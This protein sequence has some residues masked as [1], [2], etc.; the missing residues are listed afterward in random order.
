MDIQRWETGDQIVVRSMWGEKFQAVLPMRVIA[1][2]GQVLVLYLAAGTPFKNRSTYHVN[3]LPV[4]EWEIV[5]DVWTDDLVRIMYTDDN[6]AY[7]AYWRDSRFGGWYINLE[8][9]YKRTSIGIDFTDH[10]LDIVVRPE[11]AG[12]DWKDEDELAEAV[13]LNLVTQSQADE[14]YEEGRRAVERLEARRPPFGEG[15]EDFI[16]N[17]AWEIPRLSPGWDM[18]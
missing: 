6:H 1:D 10:I 5:D 17:P 13:F 2:S 4:G 11:L 18:R 7:F 16:P 12:W 8:S 15:W 9:A 14:F 3:H